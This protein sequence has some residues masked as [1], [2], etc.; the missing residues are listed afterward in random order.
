MSP[1]KVRNDIEIVHPNGSVS[2]REVLV[3]NLYFRTPHLN[4]R[5]EAAEAIRRFFA[6]VPPGG[7]EYYFDHEGEQ[8]DIDA[9]VL[10]RV[11]QERF[12][13]HPSIPNA[14][15]IIEG[16]GLYAPGFFMHYAGSAL[17]HPSMPD[18]AGTLQFWVPRA[19]FFEQRDRI[20]GYLDDVVQ[21]LPWSVGGVSLGLSGGDKVTKQAL[22]ARHPGLDISSPR[23]LSNDLGDR[24][25]GVTWHTLIGS[26]P[27]HALGGSEQIRRDLPSSASVQALPTGGCRIVLGPEPDIGDVNRRDILPTHRALAARLD[28]SGLLHVPRWVVYFHDRD[29]NAD[30]TAMEAWHRRFL[31]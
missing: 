27:V 2:I 29:G 22:A 26:G 24:V 12:Y 15:L 14:S 31:R 3:T 20:M 10:D 21:R 6:L 25:A 23:A 1:G 13:A 17:A 4:M 9:K 16:T 30:R 18:E 5:D 28:A 19:F 8:A 7:I 11:L